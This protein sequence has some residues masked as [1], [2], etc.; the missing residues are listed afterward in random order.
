M[1]IVIQ[2]ISEQIMG[3]GGGRGLAIEQPRDVKRL[4]HELG[5]RRGAA[6]ALDAQV[7][8][9]ADPHVAAHDQRRGRQLE[10]GRVADACSLTTCPLVA[11]EAGRGAVH[12]HELV[13]RGGVGAQHPEH[14]L[15]VE[16]EVDQ[17]GLGQV[18]Q[19]VQV[20]DVVALVLGLGPPPR[21]TA[22]S[23][24]PSRRTCCGTRSRACPRG[25][26]PPTAPSPAGAAT[27][28]IPKLNEPQLKV[29]ISGRHSV[30]T[31]ARSSIVIP[32]PPPVVG[33]TI[34][35]QRS[36]IAVSTARKRPRSGLGF[37]VSGS[38]TRMWTIA[39]PAACAPTA[40]STICSG[41][42]GIAGALRRHAHAAGHRAGQEDGAHAGLRRSAVSG[43]QHA[44]RTTEAP[45]IVHRTGENEP[46]ASRSAPRP[47][48]DSD[49]SA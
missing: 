3:L 27:L 49:D 39:A 37:P 9:Q 29:A 13:E 24:A 20:P 2:R 15:D 42:T 31:R 45:N 28:K 12:V 46:V 40:A 10:L 23:G 47:T 34:A 7:V 33:C 5:V 16:R 48:G 4:V 6:V 17:P 11:E 1:A 26:R 8:L 32:T 14:E 25:T 35:S 41:V 19:V 21:G 38:R 36:P 22:G 44:S 30:T 18:V 43:K